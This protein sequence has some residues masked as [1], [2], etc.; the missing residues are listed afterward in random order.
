LKSAPS[1]TSPSASIFL[2][3]AMF[4]LNNL[5]NLI[6][7]CN[8][9]QKYSEKIF[10]IKLMFKVWYQIFYYFNCHRFLSV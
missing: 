5:S 10:R 7:F 4:C 2:L 6:N 9:F 1:S 3:L 8:F